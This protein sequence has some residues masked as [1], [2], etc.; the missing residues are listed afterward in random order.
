MLPSAW[1]HLAGFEFEVKF[2]IREDES[3]EIVA[4]AF[5]TAGIYCTRG[6]DGEF[7]EATDVVYFPANEAED[8]P[9]KPVAIPPERAFVPQLHSQPDALSPNTYSS[10]G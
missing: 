5:S 4:G 7:N 6:N 3:H 8:L 1:Q 10:R 9:L 2:T